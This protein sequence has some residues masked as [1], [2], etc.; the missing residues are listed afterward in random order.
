MND[1]FVD[2][3]KLSF[4]IDQDVFNASAHIKNLTENPNIDAALNGVINLANVSKAYPVKLEKPL[5]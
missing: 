2:L 1:T 4:A 3:D 5:N